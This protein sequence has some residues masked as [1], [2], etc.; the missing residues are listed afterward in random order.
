MNIQPLTRCLTALVL[1]AI[2]R[3][4]LNAAEPRSKMRPKRG[5]YPHS[6]IT[7]AEGKVFTPKAEPLTARSVRFALPADRA[8]MPED[9]RRDLVNRINA[10]YDAVMRSVFENPKTQTGRR[11][12]EE[13][14]HRLHEAWEDAPKGSDLKQD[15]GSMLIAALAKAQ[16]PDEKDAKK[17]V[18]FKV[19]SFRSAQHDHSE[20]DPLYGPTIRA[21]QGSR[22]LIP[23]LNLLDEKDLTMNGFE[24]HDPVPMDGQVN[25]PHG[26]DVINLHTHGLNVSP[27]WP[28]DDVFRAIYPNQLKFYVYDIP[29]D[30]PVGTFWYHPHKHGSTATEVAGCMAGALIIEQAGEGKPGLDKFAAKLG[31]KENKEPLVLHQLRLYRQKSGSAK[32]AVGN[33]FVFRPD[34]FAMKDMATW[35][36]ARNQISV[37]GEPWNGIF[38][39]D[40]HIFKRIKSPEP[41]GL[42]ADWMYNHLES[43]DA[44]DGSFVIGQDQVW[45][46]G[47]P[48]INLDACATGDTVRLRLVHAGIE[49]RWRVFFYDKDGKVAPADMQVIAWDG[50]PL[51]EPYRVTDWNNAPLLSP[52]NRA[53]LLVHFAAGQEGTYAMSAG[54]SDPGNPVDLAKAFAGATAHI[55]VNKGNADPGL[56]AMTE[57][58]ARTICKMK[59]DAPA[60]GSKADFDV[61]F[62]DATV[63]SRFGGNF[64]ERQVRS[65]TF[66]INGSSFPGDPAQ[67]KRFNL[68]QT[69]RISFSVNDAMHPM[70][71]HV[72]PLWLEPDPSRKDQGLPA[73]GFWTDTLLV[74]KDVG[75][76]SGV[77]PFENWTGLTVIHCHILDHEDNGMMNVIQIS[78]GRGQPVPPIS[79]V[80]DMTRI[81]DS[82]KAAMK[83]V[84]PKSGPLPDDASQAT[85]FAFLPRT[86]ED[87]SCAQCIAMVNSIAS[88]RGAA[89]QDAKFRIVVIAGPNAHGAKDLALALNLDPTRDFFCADENLAVCRGLALI[90][91]VPVYENGV[92][93]YEHPFRST[94]RLHDTDLMHGVFVVS[95]GGFVS[96]WHRTFIALGDSDEILREIQ[97]A[98]KDPLRA[99]A[100]MPAEPGAVARMKARAEEF[101][102][103]TR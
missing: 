18:P 57:G 47:R 82:V 8:A 38:P 69:A 96:A 19:W 44:G 91:G 94:G 79:D 58:D 13:I 64:G 85:V 81:P 24:V 14:L 84:W 95:P 92:Y 17:T 87:D 59:P 89:G 70:H 28:A 25:S 51:C 98:A 43:A 36:I 75:P 62:A 35:D 77:M 68:G 65:G 20:N 86:K 6:P 50:L 55:T 48:R 73:C 11:K 3:P 99:I 39:K 49:E 42:L 56:A 27:S 102:R 72:N 66:T 83:P 46:N 30:H 61:T 103:A 22:L 45:M 7:D 53:E 15:I 4:S 21:A 40:N 23:M 88:L 31:W 76:A 37:P 100:S 78:D 41:I 101:K 54:S 5:F 90:D 2:M 10:T 74:D 60:A 93:R 26:F 97:F 71:I 12:T 52:G 32:M 34:F 16:V 9:A 80:L 1:A 63:E 67:L 29:K 33:P